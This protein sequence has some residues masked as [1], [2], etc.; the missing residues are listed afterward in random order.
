MPMLSLVLSKN[1]FYNRA[2]YDKENRSM[3]R[4]IQNSGITE[5]Q[6]WSD[7]VGSMNPIPI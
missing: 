1:T 5:F 2:T 4:A 7:L 3:N 6:S